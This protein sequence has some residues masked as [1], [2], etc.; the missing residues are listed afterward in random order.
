MWKN[1]RPRRALSSRPV[2]HRR[3]SRQAPRYV[4]EDPASIRVVLPFSG[5]HAEVR[6][7]D[8]SK[9]GLKLHAVQTAEVDIPVQRDECA[10]DLAWL[11]SYSLSA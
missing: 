11:S 8:V 4:T 7:L 1:H 9:G 3:K 6:I 2:P 5:L 10:P